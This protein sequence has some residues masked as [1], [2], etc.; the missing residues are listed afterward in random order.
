MCLDTDIEH[1]SESSPCR[2]AAHANGQT[3]TD[4]ML[5]PVYI[6]HPGGNVWRQSLKEVKNLPGGMYLVYISV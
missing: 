6:S 2:A 5:S 1:A 4:F 3:R